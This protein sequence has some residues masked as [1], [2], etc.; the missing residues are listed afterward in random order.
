MSNFSNSSRSP[1]S[2]IQQTLSIKNSIISPLLSTKNSTS[3][4]P[5]TIVTAI[6]NKTD[7]DSVQSEVYEITTGNNFKEK[8]N[9]S[10]SP[11]MV[12]VSSAAST[13][14][15]NL[16]QVSSVSDCQ[17]AVIRTTSPGISALPIRSTKAS[18]LRAAALG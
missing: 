16:P 1:N 10:V 17:S 18:R 7:I 4:S 15:R 5:S 14:T 6:N 3:S 9:S 2:L 12:M 8:S 13:P 11:Q